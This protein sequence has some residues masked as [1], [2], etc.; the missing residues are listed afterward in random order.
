MGVSYSCDK[1][2]KTIHFLPTR[3]AF[4]CSNAQG[5]STKDLD[6]SNF[7]LQIIQKERNN[8]IQALQKG[9][10]PKECEGCCEYKEI[11][12]KTF[13]Q[14]I[15]SK[16]EE[17]NNK[18]Q[19]IIIDHYKQ[20]DCNCIYCS[21]KLLYPNITQNYEVLPFIRELYKNDLI[22]K[23]NLLVEFQGGNISLLTEFQSLMEEFNK[24]NATRYIF[25]TNNIKYIEEIEKYGN[26]PDSILSV[27]LDAGTK[28]T[29]KKIK[30]VDTFDIVVQNIKK[31]RNNTQLL[32]FLKYIILEG[33]NDNL[34]ELEHFLN[35]AKEIGVNGEVSL[36]IDYRK[37]FMNN[38]EEFKIPQVYY[39]MFNLAEDYCKKNN[40]PYKCNDY[41]KLALKK[42]TNK[43]N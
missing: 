11:E 17:K 12:S 4:C 1:L 43:F 32:I 42:G 27:S 39:D 40:L 24:E 6:F 16:Q 22:D 7:N 34:E 9:K 26:K 21:G 31:Y 36:E 23:E 33:I 19:H 37:M 20:C 28:E 8:Y 5:A 13:L 25:L 2:E 38:P 41:H 35:L 3:I 29:Y 10:L 18:I 14:K 15:F 30:G